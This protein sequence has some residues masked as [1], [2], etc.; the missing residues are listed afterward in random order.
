MDNVNVEQSY[1]DG[2]LRLDTDDTINTDDE[3]TFNDQTI[4]R[5]L[6]GAV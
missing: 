2:I 5:T 4:D 1:D 3:F 6:R